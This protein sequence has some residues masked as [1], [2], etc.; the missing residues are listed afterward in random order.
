MGVPLLPIPSVQ[1]SPVGQA[2]VGV[3]AAHDRLDNL[4]GVEVTRAVLLEHCAQ[5]RR[6][7]LPAL[8]TKRGVDLGGE[9]RYLEADYNGKL[10]AN[11]MPGDS[12][13]DRDRWGYASPRTA[14]CRATSQTGGPLE[15]EP[16]PQPGERRQLLA[17]FFRAPRQ[18][19]DAA[20]A[21]QRRLAVLVRASWASAR[22]A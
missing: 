20:P 9:F 22:G 21:G 16:Q 11:Y 14:C 1:L 6:H 19:A 13:R 5:P 7:A 8:M 18:L 12:L 10:R 15:S 2:Q 17:R 3:S 4:N